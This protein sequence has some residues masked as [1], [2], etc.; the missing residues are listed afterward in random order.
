MADARMTSARGGDTR[1][2]ERAEMLERIAEIFAENARDTGIA[3]LDE[4]VRSA[5]DRVPR[6]RFMPA[7]AL[8]FAYRDT[9]LSIGYGQTI[10]QPF[11]VALMTQLVGISDTA[12]VLEVGTGSGYQAAVLAELAHYVYSIEVVAQLASAASAVL[13]ELGYD[14]VEV[15]CGD[16]FAGWAEHAPFDAILV[17]AATPRPPPLLVEQLARGGHMV[18]PLGRPAETQDLVLV[19]KDGGGE[20]AIRSVLPVAFVPLVRSEPGTGNGFLPT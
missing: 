10:S 7:S 3:N 12:T 1:A 8:D 4:R 13:A 18:V 16:G 2:G 6:H 11:M 20:V 14:N 15:R 17:T 5:F 19:T 9:A